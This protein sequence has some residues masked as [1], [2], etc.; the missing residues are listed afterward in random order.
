MKGRKKEA[1]IKKEKKRKKNMQQW[2]LFSLR[3]KPS[4]LCEEK[5]DTLK[6]RSFLAGQKMSLVREEGEENERGRIF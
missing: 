5:I 4:K 2:G 6:K 3:H 1:E